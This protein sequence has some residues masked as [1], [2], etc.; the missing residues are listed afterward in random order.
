VTDPS[1]DKLAIAFGYAAVTLALL[2]FAAL[3]V[4]VVR[5]V[6]EFVRWGWGW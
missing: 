6:W 3:T 2:L 5:A 4:P 1:P